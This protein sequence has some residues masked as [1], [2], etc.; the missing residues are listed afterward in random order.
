VAQAGLQLIR[1][2]ISF[3]PLSR[4]RD[5]C[6]AWLRGPKKKRKIAWVEDSL[7]FQTFGY[8]LVKLVFFPLLFPTLTHTGRFSSPA[9]HPPMPR[10]ET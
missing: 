6:F 1:M 2:H 8:H 9:R 4:S 3:S 10:A 5:R 7:D